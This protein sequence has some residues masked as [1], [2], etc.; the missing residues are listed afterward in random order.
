MRTTSDSCAIDAI[1]AAWDNAVNCEMP[2][3]AGPTCRRTAS[4]RINLHG[5]EQANVCG[6]H[7]EAWRRSVLFNFG[8]LWPRCGHC[9]VTFTSLRDVFTVT[10]L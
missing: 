7:K 8:T 3:Q 1:V 10:P 5:C 4:W 9:R 6:Q 2:I